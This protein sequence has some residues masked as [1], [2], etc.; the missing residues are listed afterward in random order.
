MVAAVLVDLE[1]ARYI[2]RGQKKATLLPDPA[3]AS[4]PSEPI[5]ATSPFRTLGPPDPSCWTLP[6]ATCD[7][8]DTVI[9]NNGK[10]SAHMS[11]LRERLPFLRIGAALLGV[12]LLAGCQS[13]G[14]PQGPGTITFAAPG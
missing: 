6:L 3:S 1:R 4:G 14:S 12:A 9:G 2:P 11:K 5:R 7:G 8:R 13:L 10:R